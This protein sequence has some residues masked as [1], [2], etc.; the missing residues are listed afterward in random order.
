MSEKIINVGIAGFGMSGKIFQA[1]FLN[2][3]NRFAIK[4]VFE[5]T[6]EKSKEEYPY[7][8][9]V[10]SFEELLTDDIDLVII[11]TPNSYH[12]SMAKQA[13]ENGKNVVV[14]KPV[15]ATV[16]EAKELCAIAKKNQV[17]FSVYQ[18]RRFD[19]DFLT[20]K[21]LIEDDCLGEILDYEVHYDHYVKGSSSKKWKAKGGRG[22][23]I[24]YDLG[25]HIID[26]AYTLF[27]IPKEVYADFRKLRPESNGID[28][29]EVILYYGDKKAILSAG[30]VVVKPGPHYMVNG[31]K[32]SFLKYGMDVQE[33]ALIDG[34]RPPMES[35]GKDAEKSYGSL[36]VEK[37]GLISEKKIL[38]ILGN[39]G[40]YYDNIYDVLTNN[41]ELFVKP[42]ESVEVLKIIEAAEISNSQK[43]RIQ[44]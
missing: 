22:V 44:L 10:R 21:Q 23:N 34:M 24:L 16:T 27:G 38:T 7:V 28:N 33:N 4:K 5:R 2:A 14:E 37:E 30:E 8:E 43:K 39:Y 15:A 36:Y 13:M 12:Y 26:Q 32:G 3:D 20:V 25:V 29:F 18:N 42:E 40:N 41:A 9:I 6:S 1:P 31:R 19:G 35:W 17:I 11:S